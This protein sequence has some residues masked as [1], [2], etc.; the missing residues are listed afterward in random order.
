M[1]N[2]LQRYEV[3]PYETLFEQI[4]VALGVDKDLEKCLKRLSKFKTKLQ[5]YYSWLLDKAV[6]ETKVV[7]G[8][9]ED[10]W[11]HILTNWYDMQSDMAK[12]TIDERSVSSFMKM[13]ASTDKATGL[14]DL[15]IIR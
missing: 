8:Q 10:S 4:L 13:S 9:S 11:Y 12:G 15:D 5:C 3:N 1:S 2:I 6:E 14:S 7:F